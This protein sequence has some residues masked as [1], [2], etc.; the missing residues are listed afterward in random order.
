EDKNGEEQDSDII[1]AGLYFEMSLVCRAMDNL[2]GSL[3]NISQALKLEPNNPR[4]LDA[5]LEISIMNKDKISALDAY[6]KLAEVNPENQK[7]KELKGQVD[8]L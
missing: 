8:E 1:S 7:L 4:Y 3:V 5:K 6:E 2:Q